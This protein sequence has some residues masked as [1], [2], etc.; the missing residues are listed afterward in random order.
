MLQCT[1]CH[2]SLNNP[3]YFQE[4]VEK[5]PDYLLFDPRRID[6][7]EYLQR[8]LHQFAKGHSA[9]GTLAPELDNTLRRC[10]SC[11]S[12]D[13]THN[14]LPYKGKHMGAVSCESCHIPKLYG[15][16]LESVDWTV[17]N[18]DGSPQAAYRGVE[19]DEINAATLVAGY[20]PAL[21]PRQ[22]SD[23]TQKLAPFNLITAWYWVYGDPARPVP[24]T[25]LQSAWLDGDGYAAEILAVFDE[26]NDGQ[27]DAAELV[28]D[29]EMKETAVS[30]RLTALG[31]DNPRIVGETEAYSINHN[32]AHGDWVSK[33]CRTCHSDDSRLAQPF[34]L[35]DRTPGGVT[36]TF[37][38]NDAVAFSGEIVSGEDGLLRFQPQPAQAGL[39]ILGYSA[40]DIIDW[41]GIILFLGVLVGITAHGGLRTVAARKLAGKQHQPEIQEVYM[42]DVYERLWHWLQTI[43]ILLLIFT[44]LIIHQPDKFGAFSFNYVV[45]VHNVLAAILVINAALALF[46]HLVSGEIQQYLPRPRGFF[47]QMF[48]QAQFYLKGIFRGEPHPYE[49]TRRRKLNPLQQITYFGILNVLLPLQILTGALMWGAQRWS[50][51]AAG[52]GG[53]PFLAPFH[54]LV[55]WSFASFV[56]AH[57]YLTTTG[58]EPL[59]AIKAMMLGWDEVEVNPAV[60][61][62]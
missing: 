21:L 25:Q 18:A 11:H 22:N 45:Q 55:A 41:I 35:A 29:S 4:A 24:L 40:V 60:T 28:I 61:G 8:P 43:A 46:Y 5:R 38:S 20:E 37:V 30:N 44:G 42:Y 48:V 10:E 17:L 1:D 6:I 31:L 12:I 51:I 34:I 3:I 50:E 13:A 7:G 32:V 36:P 15:P 16:A 39:Y 47:D 56:V 54:T 26:N 14:W 52:L 59:A 19:G 57:V 62:D 49:K 27:L 58:H 33:D 53:L 23:G 2:Y 9:Q